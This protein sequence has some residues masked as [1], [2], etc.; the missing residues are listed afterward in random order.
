MISNLK[1]DRQTA[2]YD[3]KK[4]LKKLSR[5]NSKKVQTFFATISL[6]IIIIS[7]FF[8]TYNI[9]NR[10]NSKDLEFAVEHELT[11]GFSSKNKLLRVKKI[12]LTYFD[13]ETAIV[14]AS[15]LCKAL[16]HKSTI[17]KG[18][19]KKDSNKSWYLD[20]LVSS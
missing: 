1:I 20:K 9:Y 12:S 4:I 6:G 2:I 19:F 17:L 18:S 5:R 3:R 14:E 10:S 7:S 13:G 8:I 15:G 11:T 16:P